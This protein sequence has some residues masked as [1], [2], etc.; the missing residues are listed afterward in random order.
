MPVLFVGHGTVTSA[1]TIYNK[2]EDAIKALDIDG[3]V[4]T[5][6]SDLEVTINKLIASNTKSLLMFPLF[7]V[8]GHHVSKDMF[9][10]QNSMKVRIEQAG[11]EVHSIESG[12]IRN[13]IIKDYYMNKVMEWK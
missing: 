8:A 11:I 3:R 10:A 1:N 5:L 13:E 9:R 12:L 6:E 7:T 4:I 2:L